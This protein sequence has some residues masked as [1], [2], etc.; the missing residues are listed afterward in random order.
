MISS[1][2]L[3]PDGGQQRRKQDV[4]A[5]KLVHIVSCRISLS[6]L[7]F[8]CHLVRGSCRIPHKTGLCAGLGCGGWQCCCSKIAVPRLLI[9]STQLPLSVVCFFVTMMAPDQKREDTGSTLLS[10]PDD[11]IE[12]CLALLPA[13]SR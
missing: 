6:I 5:Q 3:E 1:L 11:L 9:L 2:N 10:L 4:V 13:N 7:C 12:N 8:R